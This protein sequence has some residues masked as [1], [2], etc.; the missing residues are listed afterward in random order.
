MCN[1]YAILCVLRGSN[2]PQSWHPSPSISGSDQTFLGMLSA[3]EGRLLQLLL[4]VPEEKESSDLGALRRPLLPSSVGHHG[5][6]RAMIDL[7]S[8]IYMTHGCS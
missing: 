4:C 6:M 8:N 7:W 5:K 3:C 1:S 2:L